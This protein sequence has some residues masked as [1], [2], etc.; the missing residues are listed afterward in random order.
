MNTKIT[1]PDPLRL[2]FHLLDRQIVDSAGQPVG[3][4]DDLEITVDPGTGRLVV[5]ALLSGQRVLGASHRRPDRRLDGVGRPAAATRRRSAAAAHRHRGRRRHRLRGHPADSG[6][7]DHPTPW[8]SGSPV[9]S[10]ARSR[11]PAMLASDLVGARV[12]DRQG[13]DLGTVVELEASV[14]PDGAI[15]VTH[16]LTSRRRHLRLLG[17]ERPEIRG[18]WIIARL[19]RAVQGPLRRTAHQDIDL[20]PRNR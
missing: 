4:V 11:K 5:T 3:K 12:R 10:S 9:T 18:P 1:G 2:N 8:R 19:A 6:T 15:T 17:Y 14:A 16:V 13:A 7:A 20:P